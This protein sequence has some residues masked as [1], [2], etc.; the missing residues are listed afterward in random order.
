MFLNNR[1]LGVLRQDLKG[2]CEGVR[3]DGEEKNCSS[4]EEVVRGGLEALAL[5]LSRLLVLAEG[6][7]A[8]TVEGMKTLVR[9]N[10]GLDN[11]IRTA[12]S[13]TGEELI[14]CAR[15]LV[16][17]A[18]TDDALGGRCHGGEEVGR[19]LTV[20]TLESEVDKVRLC[21]VGRTKEDLAAFVDNE[22][23]V[24]EINSTAFAE[25]NPRVELSQHWKGA[26]ESVASAMVTRFLSPPE[27]PRIHDNIPHMGAVLVM[28]DTSWQVLRA[29]RARG[30]GEC[31][32]DRKHREVHVDFG[33][34]DS[35]TLV[36]L[37]HLL[38][39]NTV[40]V[41]VGAV[42]DE[43]TND[44]HFSR[45][46]NTVEAAE[47]IDPALALVGSKHVS[48]HAGKTEPNVS[49]VLLIVCFGAVA[50]DVHVLE[51]DTTL[52]GVEFLAVRVERRIGIPSIEEIGLAP[53]EV[54]R[55]VRVLSSE[56]SHDGVS[57][58]HLLSLVLVLILAG[59][60][61]VVHLGSR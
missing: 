1:T 7:G 24:E 37:V 44:E 53:L 17:K 9:L 28:V 38:R 25:S 41:E 35:F 21:F 40:V 45:V 4:L 34:V 39:W 46:D 48:C 32:S 47:D 10:L 52:S 27:T 16:L 50:K 14:G 5:C 36:V 15:H 59:A 60:G 54:L 43:D 49:N 61:L 55:S 13:P 23:L 19:G 58:D 33:S 29:S 56:V 26:F 22:S 31:V 42:I 12:L 20:G 51:A 18:G 8:G 3:Q 6:I 11:L 57:A 30:K 2:R